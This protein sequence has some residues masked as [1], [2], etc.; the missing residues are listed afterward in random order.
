MKYIKPKIN[1][2]SVAACMI[3]PFKSRVLTP[4]WHQYFMAL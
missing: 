4:C 3:T 1:E 2:A